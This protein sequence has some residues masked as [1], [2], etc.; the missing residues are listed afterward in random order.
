MTKG[1]CIAFI[2]DGKGSIRYSIY[3]H[4]NFIG[5]TTVKVGRNTNL[6]KYNGTFITTISDRV[7][8]V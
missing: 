2:C 7:K 3:K 8:R 6:N 5:S 1:N 4:E